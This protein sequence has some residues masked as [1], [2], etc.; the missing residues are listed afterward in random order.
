MS[1][2]SVERVKVLVLGD[3]GVGKS[4]VVQLICS[5]RPA[6]RSLAST[7]GCNVEVK[8]HE[9]RQGTDQQR[10][11]FVEFWEIGGNTGHANAR[12][13]FYNSVHGIVLVHDLTNS[14][15]H[16]HL[17][18]WLADAV[19]RRSGG[20][21]DAEMF[22]DLQVPVLVV[23]TKLSRARVQHRRG[24]HIADLCGAEQIFVDS[25]GD[26][27]HSSSLAPGSSNAV[28]LSRFFD[29]VIEKQY[30]SSKNVLSPQPP[31]A[32]GDRRRPANS[33]RF[34]QHVD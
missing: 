21:F 14:K 3:S 9:Y 29:K 1:T 5:G 34:L 24:T 2:I 33:P 13:V 11:F 12:R 26:G 28:K 19:T 32:F 25:T 18:M 4:S 23:G 22:A 15:S 17:K 8:L 10:T 6:A 30:Y 20:E 16:D 7:I 27:E 31:S